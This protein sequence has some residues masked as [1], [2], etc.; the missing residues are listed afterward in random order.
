M[1]TTG[2]SNVKKLTSLI[3][4]GRMPRNRWAWGVRTD[5]D[6]V[7]ET[8][9]E[10]IGGLV[11]SGLHLTRQSGRAKGEHSEINSITETVRAVTF[12]R[13]NRKAL[14][15]DYQCRNKCRHLRDNK[16][17]RTKVQIE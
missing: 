1:I 8:G 12:N 2:G 11:M 13:L 7:E 5:L 3:V 9:V 17:Y 6:M 15:M 10:T 16:H 14:Q 4:L